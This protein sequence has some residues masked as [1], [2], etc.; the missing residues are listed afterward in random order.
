MK[1][2]ATLA[3]AAFLAA[4]PAFAT[5]NL[6]SNGDFE[7]SKSTSFLGTT[8][9]EFED[10][11][12]NGGLESLSVE[13]TDIVSGSQALHVNGSKL[14]FSQA[15]LINEVNLLDDEVGQK[16]ELTIHYKVISGN[17][18][19]IFLN[20]EWTFKS[21]SSEGHDADVLNQDL[22]IGEGW[23]EKKVSTTKPTNGSRLN[24]SVGVKKGVDVIFDDFRLERVTDGTS[25]AITTTEIDL[26]A[27]DVEIYTIA[28]Q[29]IN[30]LQRGINIVKQGNK[31]SKILVR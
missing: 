21:P 20:S 28:G 22:T 5:E 30:Q 25:T 18:G 6:I 16:Y 8:S 10:W 31:I 4:A 12:W 14:T 1:K 24:V 17:A 19:D 26:N 2:L 7:T 23:Q 13:T 9:T 27:A 3:A 11:T 15:S 29:R